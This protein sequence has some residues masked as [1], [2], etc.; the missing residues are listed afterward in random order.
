MVII[1][2]ITG[3]PTECRPHNLTGRMDY[4]GPI[5]NTTARVMAKAMGGQILAELNSVMNVKMSNVVLV[6]IGKI[7]AIL[8]QSEQVPARTTRTAPGSSATSSASRA[9]SAARR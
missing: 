1:I 2:I 9:A 4:F 7:E 8:P 6:D 3:K 5:V